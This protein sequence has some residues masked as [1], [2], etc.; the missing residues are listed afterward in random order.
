M[1]IE[2]VEEIQTR[3]YSKWVNLNDLGRIDLPII[4]Q[5]R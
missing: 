5:F 3:D 4:G 1:N 2:R